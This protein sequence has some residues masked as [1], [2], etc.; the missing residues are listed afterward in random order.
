MSRTI[1]STFDPPEQR[2][3][4]QTEI[5]DT[6][7][8]SGW[9]EI[10]TAVNTLYEQHRGTWVADYSASGIL[11]GTSV[12]CVY[13]I[14]M[15]GG[16]STILCRVY[17]YAVVGIGGNC[18]VRATTTSA[19]DTVSSSATGASFQGWVNVGTLDVDATSEYETLTID[20]T[21]ATSATVYGLV[22][23]PE[24]G[25]TAHTDAADDWAYSD[26]FVPLE[27]T[28]FGGERSLSATRA[29][30]VHENLRLIWEQRIPQAIATDY[31][32]NPL[33]GASVYADVPIPKHLQPGQTATL[34]CFIRYAWTG[35]SSGVDI[36]SASV[37]CQGSSSG[38]VALSGGSVG[39]S[40]A[41]DLTVSIDSDASPE[42]TT[43]LVTLAVSASN[44]DVYGL[45]AYWVDLTYG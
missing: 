13:R 19:A 18:V 25:L 28:E 6:L 15:W 21:T 23:I 26:G 39:W 40:S 16:N 9:Q 36:G 11:A 37:S 32:V 2:A 3:H 27:I 10:A 43:A 44:I 38:V 31:S 17:A 45:S 1:D 34:R 33:T 4:A 30:Q 22:A 20:L 24:R 5:A 41:R 35:L 29:R 7:R 12:D 42:Q 14:K 8:G